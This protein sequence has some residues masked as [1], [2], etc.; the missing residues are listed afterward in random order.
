MAKLTQKQIGYLEM[1][2]RRLKI[3]EK[4]ILSQD[5]AVCRKGGA[6][7]TTLHYTRQD[8]SVLYEINKEAGS[9]LVQLFEAKREL[10]HFINPPRSTEE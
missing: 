4:F 9:Q 3:T 2:L 10:E 6:A 8:G 5:I 7:S 1:V